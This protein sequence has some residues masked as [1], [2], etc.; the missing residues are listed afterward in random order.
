VNRIWFC[1]L[2]CAWSTGVLAQSAFTP[3]GSP[4][5]G[6]SWARD[7]SG[8]G[9]TVVGAG[10]AA[11]GAERIGFRWTEADGMQPLGG[12]NT[13]A[14]AASTDGSVIVGQGD[15]AAG[16]TQPFRWTVAT[17][18]TLLGA[19]DDGE[20]IALGVSGDGG[21]VVGESGR[22]PV[23]D[24]ACTMTF[25]EIVDPGTLRAFIWTEG[26]GLKTHPG[27]VDLPFSQA[28]G[29]SADGTV[30]AGNAY[31]IRSSCGA[32]DGVCVDYRDSE[33]PQQSLGLAPATVPVGLLPGD[34][35]AGSSAG[36]DVLVGRAREFSPFVW[37]YADGFRQL[38]REP[39]AGYIARDVS[40]DGSLVVGDFGLATAGR[41]AGL[42]NLLQNALGIEVLGWEF[43]SDAY[44]LPPPAPLFGGL[45]AT[46]VSDDGLTIV[47]AG[48]NPRGRVEAFRLRL[49]TP[50]SAE[51]FDG[52]PET[53]VS[54]VLGAVLPSARS[55][56][57]GSVLPVY[58]T[59][60]NPTKIDLVA[61][62][63]VL[64]SDV[65]VDF[66]YQT[67][68]PL[69]NDLVGTPNTPVDVPAGGAQTFV[70]AFLPTAPF[71]PAAVRLV[72]DC[73][74]GRP[75]ETAT[76]LNDL[77]LSASDTPV[78]D[79]LA[80]ART[81]SGDGVALLDDD[82]QGAFVVA[83]TNFGPDQRLTVSALSTS[84]LS[85]EAELCRSDLSTG[86]C[87]GP[88]APAL[89]V[90]MPRDE[91]V[92]FSV[93]VA[94]GSLVIPDYAAHR[95][96]VTFEGTGGAVRGATSVAVASVF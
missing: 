76:G 61:C 79:V 24:P 77:L 22:P 40:A 91:V 78:A 15:T 83:G 71:D 46:G 58:A 38:I 45:G 62:G 56:V 47:G 4:G 42:K 1:A 96:N 29:V 32:I 36:G 54:P 28:I 16:V 18:L 37:S 35:L 31:E 7:V 92:T 60:A 43:Q 11:D 75:A 72:F 87:V 81:P 23:P 25:C 59:L 95:V 8:D 26:D 50:L 34:V 20:G 5:P 82:G 69:N 70:L 49:D 67:S 41:T 84:P 51:D 89:D 63:V 10:F 68:E 53:A 44:A 13:D 17:G 19:L 73:S 93:F 14:H 2:V 21:I 39:F 33:L 74:N 85:F 30:T 94:A 64:G 80:V 90:D 27:F 88:V 55:G 3:L 48:R 6:A 86:S 12:I 9:T 65:P 52:L 66:T 57:V